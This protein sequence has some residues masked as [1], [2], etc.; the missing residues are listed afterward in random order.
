MD[1]KRHLEIA[2]KIA[3]LQETRFSIWKFKFG[4]DPIIGLI[5]GLGDFLT[6]GLSFY[7][8]FV[9]ILHQIPP[10][11]IVQMTTYVLLDF[12]VGSIP[13]IGDLLDFAVKPNIKNLAILER[14]LNSPKTDV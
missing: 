3:A 4:L 13:L 10:R 5:P 8:V 11:R 2:R 12:I 14:E 9:A 1:K 7:L 6:T